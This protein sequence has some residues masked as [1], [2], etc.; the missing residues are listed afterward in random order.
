MLGL[1]HFFKTISRCFQQK[2]LKLKLRS[3]TFG[4][5]GIWYC[6]GSR[7]NKLVR[8]TFHTIVKSKLAPLRALPRAYGLI[9]I[10]IESRLYKRP[11]RTA[12]VMNEPAQKCKMLGSKLSAPAPTWIC[13]RNLGHWIKD[14]DKTHDRTVLGAESRLFIEEFKHNQFGILGC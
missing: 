13:D 10:T 1:D 12:C 5:G 4:R 3:G 8:F 11:L 14:K 9:E 7:Y 6:E 2:I